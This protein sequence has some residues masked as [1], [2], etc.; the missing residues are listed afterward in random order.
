MDTSPIIEVK[1]LSHSYPQGFG[2][3]ALKKISFSVSKG[4]VFGLLGPN[5]GGKTT[6]F[7]ILSTLLL[8]SQGSACLFGFDVRKD[9][10]LVRSRIG[11]VFQSQSLDLKLT[12]EENLRHHGHLYGLIGSNLKTQIK[13]TLKQLGLIGRKKDR[14]ETLSG[15]LKRR[16]ELAK[17]LLHN[18]SLLLLDEPTAGLDPGVRRDLWEYLNSLRLKNGLT[19]LLT[20]HLLDE[21]ERCNRVGFL[22]E[23]RLVA[24]DSPE[25]LKKKLGGEI[26]VVKTKD[27]KYLQKEIED[28]F[29]IHGMIIDGTLRLERQRAHEFIAQLMDAFGGQVQTITLAHPT[30][31]DVF[32]RET[33][34]NFWSK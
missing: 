22:D 29:K 31:E 12:V 4:E 33:G 24:L 17:A 26:I 34:H 20:T 21:A 15:G 28:K 1:D 8:P 23:G 9:S 3:S 6:A 16:V 7:K 14:I 19:I 10:N 2:R 11:V 18:P 32:I 30:L 25:K 27:P 13:I 5:G